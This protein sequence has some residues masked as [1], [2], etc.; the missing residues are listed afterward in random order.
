MKNMGEEKGEWAKDEE[1]N[2]EKAI[3]KG[4]FAPF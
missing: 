2:P 3:K 4:A 1:S